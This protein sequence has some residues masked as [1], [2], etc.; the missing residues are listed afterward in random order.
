MSLSFLN[1]LKANT[2]V[3]IVFYMCAIVFYQLVTIIPLKTG[4]VA[5]KIPEDTKL[6]SSP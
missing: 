3:A 2:S 1:F 5:Y 6:L 4:V